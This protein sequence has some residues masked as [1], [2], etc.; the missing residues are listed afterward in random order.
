VGAKLRSW[1]DD[2]SNKEFFKV[3]ILG[4][5]TITYNIHSIKRF[6]EQ[7]C[8]NESENLKLRFTPS[9]KS[10]EG[11]NSLKYTSSAL[12]LESIALSTSD[13]I[14]ERDI[15]ELYKIRA[16]FE[17]QYDVKLFLRKKDDF[18]EIEIVFWNE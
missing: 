6:I 7:Y 12:G 9:R 4:I 13:E 3:S 14:F 1:I 10:P 16:K 15:K 2:E 17:S 5:Q 11:R 18:M 8:E